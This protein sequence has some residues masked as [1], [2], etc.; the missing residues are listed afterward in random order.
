M[1][2]GVSGSGPRDTPPAT[3]P[4][5]QL[6]VAAL[7]PLALS[8]CGGGADAEVAAF[9]SAIEALRDDDPFA[10]LTVAS[11]GEMRDAFA[12]LAEGADRAADV[13]PDD[14]AVQARRYA[15]AVEA[16]RDELAGG[17]YDP[18]QVD[19]RRYRDGVE[20]YGEAATSLANAARARCDE[21]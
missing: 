3:C 19:T 6:L 7:L 12:V 16:L 5:A 15:D 17:G 8:G 1:R 14:A 9:C 2:A 18:T 10:E 4:A 11:P 21:P 20:A 13:A